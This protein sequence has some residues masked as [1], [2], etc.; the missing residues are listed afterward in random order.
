MA[1]Q[2]FE[3]LKVIEFAWAG[4]GPQISR[5]LAEHGATVI[6]VESHK[7]LDIMRTA[8]PFRDNIPSYDRSAYFAAYNTAKRSISV[9]LAK[10]EAQDL[11]R[12]M[13]S[14]A[15]VMGEAWAPG[16]MANLGL[17]YDSVRKIN[18]RIIYFSTCMLGQTGPH[19]EF[20][21]IG[22]HLNAIGGFSDATGWP[23]GEATNVHTAYSDFIA[24]WYVLIGVI[25]ALLRRR[26]T[27]QGMYMEQAQLEAALTFL[28]PHVLD[29]VTN[30][31]L[32]RRRGN[33]DRYMCPHGVYPCRGADRWVAIAITDD[34]DWQSF[35]QVIGDP[36]WAQDPRF[37]Y[38]IGRKENE[39]ELDQRIGE[40]TKDFPPEQVMAMLQ[41]AGTAAGVVE[42]GQDLLADP[43]L[44]AREHFRVLNHPAIGPH[45]YNAPAYK[46]SST[47]CEITRP[48]PCLGEHNEYVLKDL[49]GFTDDDIADM[50][51][52]GVITTDADAPTIAA[53]M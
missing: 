31:N 44:K 41:G 23:E 7:R 27:G 14:W 36:E 26:K 52:Q 53:M 19:H 45:T 24:P 49:L 4:V 39:G 34:E 16:T 5:E 17:D 32:L 2:I 9:D 20:R 12:R 47:P 18:P 29:Y 10:P 35:R 30:Q 43:Q 33:R 22:N 21:G 15:D 50:L 46:L 40:W 48:A 37:D 11:I 13:V 28:G 3:G 6:K 25:G 51:V 1:K 42:T 38:V 8:P